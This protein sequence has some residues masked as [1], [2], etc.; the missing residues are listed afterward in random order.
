MPHLIMLFKKNLNRKW[1]ERPQLYKGR[2]FY[3]RRVAQVGLTVFLGLSALSF[4]L[5]LKNSTA[6]TIRKIEVLGENA[7]VAK[8]DVLTLAGIKETDKLFALSFEKVQR[9]IREHPWVKGVSLRREFPDTIQIHI[10]EHKPAALLLAGDLYYVD[11]DGVVFKKVSLGERLGFP[12]IS[13][14]QRGDL[15]D[16]PIF[17]REH[18]QKVFHALKFFSAQ[19]FFRLDTISE[20]NYDFTKGITVFTRE[21]GMEV[22]Y[23]TGDF[24]KLQQKLEKFKLSK[25]GK[26]FHF[27]RLDVSVPG[28][29]VA[30]K[31]LWPKKTT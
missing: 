27:S 26:G 18:L 4:V 10:E 2:F 22:F 12:V 1:Q 15:R 6:L 8:E 23:G 24:T 7:H 21:W 19:S 3:L 25:T 14:F 30:R 11:E 16:Y 29:V 31:K 5:Y 17:M 9:R 28:K 20:I 13:G